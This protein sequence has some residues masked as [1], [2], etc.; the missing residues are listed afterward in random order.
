MLPALFLLYVVDNLYVSA[1]KSRV[2]KGKR[3]VK[4]SKSL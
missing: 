4:I 2:K 1:T 3:R